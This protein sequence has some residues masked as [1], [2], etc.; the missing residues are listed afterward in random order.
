MDCPIFFFFLLL[1]LL[2]T[3]SAGFPR[4]KL[5]TLELEQSQTPTPT[6]TT[7][8]Q[9][10][11]PI[12]PPP[13]S[14]HCSTL[15]LTHDFAYTYTKPPVTSLYNP[16]THCTPRAPPSLAVLEFSSTCIGRQ[17]DRIFGVWLG[18]AEILRSCTAEPR[19]SGI[20]WSVQKDITSYSSLLS[21][22]QTLAVYLG[23][24]VDATYTGV[25]HVNVSIHLY[26]DHRAADKKKASAAAAAGF[27][28]PADLIVPLS[29]PLPLNDGLWFQ[30]NDS[31]DIET[32]QFVVPANT[33]RAVLE[34]YV[35]FHSDDEFWYSN[36]PDEYISANNL[37]SPGNGAFRE[38]TVSLDGDLVGVIW[39]FTVI[40]TGGINPLL[41]RP[42]TGVGSFD[43]PTYDIDVTPFLGKVLDGKKHTIG[44]GV[45]N[46]L[47]VWYVDGNLHLWLDSK[48]SY[49]VGSLIEYKAPGFRPSLVSKFKGLDG[50][51]DTRAH[52]Q[53]SATGWVKSSHGKITT[54]FF[55][56]LDYENLMEFK[57]N[58][59]VQVVNQT[60]EFS[61][62]TYAKHP[63]TVLYSEQ[64]YRKFP[65]YLYT[66]SSD[67]VNDSYS[68]DANVMLGYDEK[69]FS[70]ERFGF[71]FST[72][73]NLQNAQGTMYVKGNLVTGGLGSTQEVYRYE[74]T[75]GCYFRNVSSSNYTIL[76]D[77]SGNSCTEDLGYSSI[78]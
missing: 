75:E 62:G 13:N 32:E 63:A 9:V 47:D 4:S 26:F 68:L 21:R 72:L 65:L 38:V 71:S 14:T 12:T 37:S 55:Q 56:R 43:L 6:P 45:T 5:L 44:F 10:T 59:S 23:N 24:I 29:R 53:I 33:F 25:Y 36:P 34:V 48:S 39:P 49:T 1:T 2:P 57:G 77:E 67:E 40:Y 28:S 41:W 16:P 78:R 19:A 20:A 11:R 42:I 70:G 58:G 76:H 69:R 73:R 66:G 7:F 60:I 46:G 50:S 31:T 35:S 15:V 74:S 51:F 27:G 8:F 17:F 54:N 3:L 52:R 61:Y 64:V 30:V 22:P 18:G